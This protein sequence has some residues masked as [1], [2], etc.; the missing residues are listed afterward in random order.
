MLDQCSQAEKGARA[1]SPPLSQDLDLG[2][3][4]LSLGTLPFLVRTENYICFGGDLQEHHDLTLRTKDL[5]QEGFF[6]TANHA[7]S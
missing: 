3:R 1:G 7:L 5:R 4:K 6:G 2:G